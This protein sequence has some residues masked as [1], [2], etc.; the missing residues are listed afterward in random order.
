MSAPSDPLALLK[1]L[2]KT[3]KHP[4]ISYILLHINSRMPLPV[5]SS[6]QSPKAEGVGVVVFLELQVSIDQISYM[7]GKQETLSP[8]PLRASLES[9][10]V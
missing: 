3:E 2:F 6:S 4:N 5:A 1:M 8:F 9:S 10:G 7:L